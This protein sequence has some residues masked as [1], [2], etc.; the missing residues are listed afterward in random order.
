M[1]RH[2]K[3]KTYEWTDSEHWFDTGGDKMCWVCGKEFDLPIIHV[4]K[5]ENGKE[6]HKV[7]KD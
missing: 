2:P 3:R 5:K 4:L 1:T 6:M 7:S